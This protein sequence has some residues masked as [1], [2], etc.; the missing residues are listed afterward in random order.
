LFTSDDTLLTS[1][2]LFFYSI[3]LFSVGAFTFVQRFFYS[4]QLYRI[5]FFTAIG[6]SIADI[7]LTLWLKET[8]LRA[9]GIALANSISFSGGLVVLILLSRAKLAN[10]RGK[11]IVKTALKVFVS[12]AA[13]IFASISFLKITGEWWLEGSSIRTILLLSAGVFIYAACILIFYRFLGVEMLKA[14]KIRSGAKT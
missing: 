8:G 5:P 9:A 14:L 1:K 6:I 3:G 7:I 13:A 12:N 4:L 10:L 2:I 11:T